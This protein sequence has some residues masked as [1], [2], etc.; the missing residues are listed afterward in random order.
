MW[1]TIF[2][3]AFYSNASQQL[4]MLVIESQLFAI[5]QEGF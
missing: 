2:E 5:N 3:N 4:R 1:P